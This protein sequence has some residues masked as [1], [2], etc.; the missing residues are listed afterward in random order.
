MLELILP[1]APAKSGSAAEYDRPSGKPG[2]SRSVVMA[3]NGMV[4]T[5]QPLAAQAGLEVLRS[6]GNAV[7]A[8]I[9]VNAMLGVVEPMSCGIGGDL[10]VIYWDAKTETL[11][12]LNASGRSPYGL[13]REVFKERELTEIPAE[14]PLAWSVPGCVDG[15]QMLSERFGARPLAELLQPAIRHAEEGFPVSEII[16]GQWKGA[17]KSFESWPDSAATW[18]IDGRPPEAGEIFRNPNLAAT[19]RLIAAGGRDAFYEGPIAQQIVEFSEAHG[20]CF[21]MQD[22]ADHAGEW[23]EPV[24]TRYRGYDVWE[25]P[26]NGQGIAALEMLNILEAYDVAKMGSH[27]ADYLHLLVEAKKLAFADRAK[28]YADPAFADVPVAQLVSKEYANQQRKRIDPNRAAVDVPAGAPMLQA[29]DTVYLSVVDQDRNCCSFIQSNYYG[30]GSKATPGKLGF[31]LQ[32]RG[33]LFSL[34]ES[35]ANTLEPHKRPFHT[36]IPAMVTREGKPWLC[37][38]VMGGDMQPQ[39]HVQILVNMIDFGMNVQAAGDAARMRHLGSAT[40][41]GTPM[42]AGGGKVA[43]ESGIPEATVKLL[44]ERGHEVIRSPV[45]FGGYQGIRIDFE[46]GVLHGGTDPRKDGAAVGY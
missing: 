12:G 30:F 22:F 14:G 36:I 20:G 19:Y 25:L 2:Q 26:P 33:A 13:N 41:T 3:R 6:G 42:Q 43:V 32:N 16:A 46:Q 5:S 23:V 17:E 11:Y 34:D 1:Y 31:C 28:F 24:S 9:A 44:Q 8:A 38:G 4:A 29:G 7:D 35:H 15:W 27:S 10:F 37:F 39:G 45:S 21:S 18:L 40:P